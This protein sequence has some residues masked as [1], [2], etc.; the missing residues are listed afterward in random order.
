MWHYLLTHTDKIY[1]YEYKNA[2]QL[3]SIKKPSTVG[4]NYMNPTAFM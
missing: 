3:G 1:T 4:D 2:M